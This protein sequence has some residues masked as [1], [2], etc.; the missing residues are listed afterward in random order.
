M[1]FFFFWKSA[2]AAEAAAA[3]ADATDDFKLGDTLTS[4][5]IE[6]A[7]GVGVFEIGRKNSAIFYA[8]VFSGARANIHIQANTQIHKICFYVFR[9]APFL[10][11][12]QS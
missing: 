1:C 8:L 3:A 5:N 2:A 7:G 11:V 6:V 12:L 10:A 4:G 9:T